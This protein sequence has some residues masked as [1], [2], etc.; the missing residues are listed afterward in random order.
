MQDVLHPPSHPMAN[1]K[2]QVLAMLIPSWLLC[3]LFFSS[4]PLDCCD[5]R[6]AAKTSNLKEYYMHAACCPQNAYLPRDLAL[7][8]SYFSFLRQG[9][10]PMSG[11]GI[12]AVNM[13]LANNAF[14]LECFRYSLPAPS[15]T[16]RVQQG[17]PATS[18]LPCNL[19]V[20]FLKLKRRKKGVVP[21]Q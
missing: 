2:M 7:P 21:L 19:A 8:F 17:T 3:L 9:S 15:P 20:S 14:V 5:T 11:F 10:K 16:E 1:A 4:L 18:F 6:A 13:S 12:N